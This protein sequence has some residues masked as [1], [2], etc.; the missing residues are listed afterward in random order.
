MTLKGLAKG[1][2]S[3]DR[4]NVGT[5]GLGCGTITIARS[6]SIFLTAQLQVFFA[7]LRL[8]PIRRL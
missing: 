3:K 2:K 5:V 1:H 4:V 8:A 6:Q 7:D